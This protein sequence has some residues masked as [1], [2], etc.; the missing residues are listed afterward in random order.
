MLSCLALCAVAVPVVS[1]S[2]AAPATHAAVPPAPAI[3]L[4]PAPGL[5]PAPP[6][7]PGSPPCV[8][9][10]PNDPLYQQLQQ[11][12]AQQAQLKATKS[13]LSGE[14]QAAKDQQDNL[15]SLVDANRKA[16][17]DTLAR[18]AVEEQKYQSAQTR[19]DQARQAAADARRRETRDKALLAGYVRERYV[20]QDTFAD[21][22]LSADSFPEVLARSATLAHLAANGAALVTKVQGDIRE[23]ELAEQAAQAAANQARQAADALAQ[24]KAD[25]DQQVSNDQ[26]IIVKLGANAAAAS[27][28]IQQ[29]DTQ[30]A[31]LAQKIA[32][33]RIQ[34]IDD[35]ILQAEQAAWTE[36]SYYVQHNLSGLPASIAA[37][38]APGTARLIW[39][40]PGTTITQPFG[41]SPYQFE[42]AAFGVPHFHTGI[43]LGGA[44]GTPIYA[45]ANGVVV[46]ASRGTLGYGNHIIVA[47][48]AHTLTLYGHLQLM[49]VKPGDN[50]VQGQPIALMGSTGNS[51]GPHLH[52][53]VRIDNVTADPVPFLP[54][55]AQGA[56]GPAPLS[57]SPPLP[58]TPPPGD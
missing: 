19:A 8:P 33:L 48:D 3:S 2:T 57:S 53:E 24:Q 32:D 17:G 26:E 45:P 25:L 55:L 12:L 38:A 7:A 44:Q 28:E 37:P 36:A 4:C 20:R 34:E 23:A 42:P 22:V 1:A 6:P 31:A 54:A 13:T 21:Y 16:I 30:D 29:A 15:R 5:P 56:S 27:T 46:A 41:P 18:M 14:I 40:A 43:D 9:Q 35:A 50:V 51:T 10:N 39:P 58:P 49:F 47:H 11:A 52:F